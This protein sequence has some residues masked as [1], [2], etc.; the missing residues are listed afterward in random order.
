LFSGYSQRENRTTNYCLLVLKLLYEENPKY[1]GEILG[2]LMGEQIS[3]LVGVQFRQQVKQ[4]NSVPDGLICQ[5]AF[6]I[7]IE[8]KNFDWFHLKQIAGHLHSLNEEAPGQKV[9]LALSNFE[10]SDENRFSDVQDLCKTKYEG[11]VVFG[12]ASFEDL[13]DGLRDIAVPKNLSDTIEDFGAYL[14]EE[15]LLPDW[16]YRLDVVNCAS[17]EEEPIKGQVYMCPVSGGSYNH[18]RSKFFGLY[19]G[20]QV[21]HVAFIEAVVDLQS[22]I[23]HQILWKN[24]PTNDKDVIKLAR[25]KLSQWRPNWYPARVFLLGNLVETSFAK[26]TP[27]GMQGT[28]QYFRVD[29][30]DA[31]ELAEQL[32][33]RNWTEWPGS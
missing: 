4:S 14:D 18:K 19:K 10:S 25:A 5:S 13:L 16:Q 23:D 9:L 26:D 1:L 33:D 15:N 32:R 7:Y 6:T 30:R 28:K 29:A 20:K 12:Y 24:I 3:D 17:L 8:T 31:E 22:E 2:K 21:S 27:K 11:S